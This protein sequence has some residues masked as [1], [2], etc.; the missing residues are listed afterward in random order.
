MSRPQVE[1][2]DRNAGAPVPRRTF[3]LAVVIVCAV[4]A[5]SFTLGLA[6]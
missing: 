2:R 4:A 5:L 1:L 6:R 3:G